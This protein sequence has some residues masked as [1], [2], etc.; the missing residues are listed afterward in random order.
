MD[1]RLFN[2]G[3]FIFT[4]LTYDFLMI[5]LWLLFINGPH[6]CWINVSP[7]FFTC[8]T[9]DTR[10]QHELFLYLMWD[11]L[12]CLLKPKQPS[13][14]TFVC[15]G[16]LRV[17]WKLIMQLYPEHLICLLEYLSPYKDSWPC[18]AEDA[19]E[20]V[21]TSGATCPPCLVPL[22][23]LSLCPSCISI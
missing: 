20:E 9:A 22:C 16:K 12:I 5:S 11:N 14:I 18:S 2:T 1:F 19:E 3:V 6:F 23:T 13:W 8:N 4:K 10:Y 7:F 21:I 15:N 17:R